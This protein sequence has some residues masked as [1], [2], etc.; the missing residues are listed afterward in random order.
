MTDYDVV[1]VGAGPGGSVAAKVAAEAGLK[2]I[3]F[4]RGRKP[5][6][7]NASGCGLG[8]R[9]WRT[10]PDMMKQLTPETVPSKR[11]TGCV[12][13][14]FIDK[15]MEEKGVTMFYPTDSVT[16]EPARQFI[17]M[18]VY[19]S[20][21]DP[22]LAKFAT[23]A[24]A[25]LRTSTLVTNLI[26]DD[27]GKTIGVL[28]EKGERILGKIIIGA[29]GVIS[30]VSTK[31]GLNPRWLPNQVTLVPQYDFSADP[32]KLDMFYGPDGLFADAAAA[33]W[34]GVTFPSAYQ[35]IFHDG[36]HIGLGSWMGQ[37]NKNPLHFLNLLVGS[38]PF[39][40]M[41]KALGA[42]PREVQ[43]HMLPWTQEPVNTYGD[44]VMLVGDAGGF[45][46]P[47][48]AEGVYPAMET[49]KLAAETAIKCIGDGDT[50][51]SA[52]KLY[53]EKWRASSVGVEFEAGE[54]LQVMWRHLMFSVQSEKNNMEWYV[55][56]MLEL[57]GGYYDWSE[58]HIIRF[59]QMF[60][61]IRE[62]A[63]DAMPFVSKYMLP[64]LSD[65]LE[66]D[67]STLPLLTKLMDNMKPKKKKK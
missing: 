30:M 29:D 18:N 11:M 43:T 2:T 7:K 58:A 66:E 42:K 22:W 31:S 25:E 8:P 27:K 6:E 46:C 10:F 16:Y 37:W 38:K 45:P 14:H 32:D 23:D 40:R 15:N 13:N 59:R 35:V 1:I 50:S 36:F 12:V 39:Q 33:C 54:S 24:G 20:E 34:W 49:A 21:F 44:N 51:K 17:T 41:I 53:E 63:N 48:E 47:L 55:P 60:A 26:K 62:L 64:V 65:V 57:N 52:L 67:L 4:E 9:M 5:G 19:R 3:F 56:L 28:T 61:R